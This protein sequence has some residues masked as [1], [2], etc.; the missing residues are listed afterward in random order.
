M[1]SDMASD[2]HTPKP[3]GRPLSLWRHLHRKGDQPCGYGC[4]GSAAIMDTPTALNELSRSLQVAGVRVPSGALKGGCGGLAMLATMKPLEHNQAASVGPAI[5]Q[6][7]ERRAAAGGAIARMLVHGESGGIMGPMV[8]QFLK[9]RARAQGP[10][11]QI[12]LEASSAKAACKSKPD[13]DRFHGN[14]AG[15]LAASSLQRPDQSQPVAGAVAK[16]CW[17][18][19]G[20]EVVSDCLVQVQNKSPFDMH[21]CEE[22]V[23]M[24]WVDLGIKFKGKA[25]IRAM[26]AQVFLSIPDLHVEFKNLVQ[27]T[28]D[29]I[30]LEAVVTGTQLRKVLPMFPIGRQVRWLF[31][32]SSELHHTTRR[33]VSQR[34]RF[35]ATPDFPLQPSNLAGLVGCSSL[36]SLTPSGSRFLRDTMDSANFEDEDKVIILAEIGDAVWDV[37][38]SPHGN[39]VLQKLIMTLPPPRLQKMVSVFRGRAVEAAKDQMQSRVLEKL[40]VFCQPDQISDAVEELLAKS[41]QLC[42]HPFGNFPM[43]AVLE[44]G[45]W[46]QKRRLIAAICADAGRL[47]RHRIAS[48]VVRRALLHGSEEDRQ[49]LAQGLAK[50]HGELASLSKHQV[51]SFVAKEVK[52]ILGTS[53]IVS[54]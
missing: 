53:R 34:V 52:Q 49:R 54:L 48:N 29:R 45:T 1:S 40:L 10:L 42:K 39:F 41:V 28:P 25:S 6:F 18:K 50:D 20:M 37:S 4:P 31:S 26:Y 43:Q 7:I 14:C 23:E 2:N 9:E 22:E 44:H 15:T 51:G 3:R 46:G 32:A 16:P 8:M 27:E 47:A 19:A 35:T 17:K 33:I 30:V 24:L 21:R 12:L 11:A 5:L 36:L 13:D 38:R